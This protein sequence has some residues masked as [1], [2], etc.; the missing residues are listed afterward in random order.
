[1]IKGISNELSQELDDCWKILARYY[2]D[3]VRISEIGFEDTETDRLIIMMLAGIVK[4]EL[5]RKDMNGEL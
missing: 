4:A 2:G 1:M 5:Q 3:I